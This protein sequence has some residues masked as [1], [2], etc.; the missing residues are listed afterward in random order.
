MP[1]H[2]ART[3]SGKGLALSAT[4]VLGESLL[5]ACI[6]AAGGALGHAIVVGAWAY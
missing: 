4:F 2:S 1:G 3:T 5:F 6:G